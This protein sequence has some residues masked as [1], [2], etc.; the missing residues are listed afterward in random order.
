MERN[1]PRISELEDFGTFE[2]LAKLVVRYLSGLYRGDMSIASMAIVFDKY[3]DKYSM[4]C[5]S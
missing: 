4:T 1:C 2:D 5:L 3:D